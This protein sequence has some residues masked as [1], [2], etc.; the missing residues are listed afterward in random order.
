MVLIPSD[1]LG[2]PVYPTIYITLALMTDLREY[3]KRF[4]QIFPAFFLVSLFFCVLVQYGPSVARSTAVSA[5]TGSFTVPSVIL[6]FIACT[7]LT[8]ITLLLFGS[9]TP[10]S[11]AKKHAL[12]KAF[13]QK[14]A[15]FVA[16]LVAPML[17]ATCAVLVACLL[18]GYQNKVVGLLWGILYLALFA[19]FNIFLPALAQH[20]VLRRI[21]AKVSGGRAVGAFLIIAS[22][23]LF[24]WVLPVK[25]G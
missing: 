5:I 12:I 18:F 22:V 4:G 1:I 16:D 8:G 3:A 2:C 10:E 7:A 13:V 17:A 25:S 20:S 11:S 24:Y 21:D 9:L 23:V 19:A 6:L 14:P 15:N